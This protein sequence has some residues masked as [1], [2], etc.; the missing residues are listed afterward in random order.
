MLVRVLRRIDVLSDR[1]CKKK[2]RLTEVMIY[3]KVANRRW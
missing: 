3:R 1:N 2:K